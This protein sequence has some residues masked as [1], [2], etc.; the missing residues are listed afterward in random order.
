MIIKMFNEAW[1]PFMCAVG[2]GCGASSLRMLKSGWKSMLESSLLG[3]L[4]LS[5]ATRGINEVSLCNRILSV[6]IY[7]N[8]MR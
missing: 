4:L 5:Y 7:Q 2:G 8:I 6:G 1:L 3:S